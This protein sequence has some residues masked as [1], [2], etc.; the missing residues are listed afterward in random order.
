MFTYIFN[1]LNAKNFRDSNAKMVKAKKKRAWN[2]VISRVV[3]G[4]KGLAK[5]L[6]KKSWEVLGEDPS[7]NATVC[8][9]YY[10]GEM[11]DIFRK[12]GGEVDLLSLIRCLGPEQAEKS[13]QLHRVI[14]TRELHHGITLT[15]LSNLTMSFPD[16][17]VTLAAP[18][19]IKQ[20]ETGTWINSIDYEFEVSPN[21]VESMASELTLRNV[22]E[23]LQAFDS[24]H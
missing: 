4:K 5:A 6:L 18:F 8:A 3:L 15:C 20:T 19:H 2:R 14:L 17:E 7:P 11:H 9:R 22:K 21:F 12:P 13:W 1:Q 10:L 16:A 23:W 24:R